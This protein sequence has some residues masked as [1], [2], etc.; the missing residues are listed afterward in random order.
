MRR[1]LRVR[2]G[3]R[4]DGVEVGGAAVGRPLLLAVEDVVVAV[5]DGAGAQASRRREPANFSE[6]QKATSFSPRAIRGRYFC[7]CSSV[8]P[9]M[10]GNEPSALTA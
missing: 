4:E 8:P 5:L 1:D 3:D 2:V 9:T 7:F 6:R 10:I